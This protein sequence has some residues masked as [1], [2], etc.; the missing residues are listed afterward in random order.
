MMMRAK[1]IAS[2]IDRNLVRRAA[3]IATMLGR[4]RGEA[5]SAILA[6]AEVWAMSRF[7][8]NATFML[9]APRDA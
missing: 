9:P 4:R 1:T 5:D 7:V 3:A 2:L 8:H 6:E